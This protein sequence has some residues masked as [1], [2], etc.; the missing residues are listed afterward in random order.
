MISQNRGVNVR[1]IMEA[2]FCESYLKCGGKENI[3][4][5]FAHQME[6][7][8][9]NSTLRDADTFLIENTWNNSLIQL[10]SATCCRLLANMSVALLAR[11]FEPSKLAFLS[12]EELNPEANIKERE[13]IR[14]R[15]SQI[16]E[17]KV[18]HEHTC[19]KCGKNETTVTERQTRALDE[20]STLFVTCLICGYVWK[21]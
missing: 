13:D 14:I 18:S 20:A 2:K 19:K 21:A 3:A 10:Y 12:S 5:E 9:Y 4:K 16:I 15:E 7:G 8:C 6:I 11:G 17:R 1:A